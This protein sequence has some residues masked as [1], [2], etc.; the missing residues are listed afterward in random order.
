MEN[1][2]FTLGYSFENIGQANTE[3]ELWIRK[4]KCLCTICFATQ[5]RSLNKYQLVG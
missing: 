2:Q 1:S 3:L 5:K 4:I